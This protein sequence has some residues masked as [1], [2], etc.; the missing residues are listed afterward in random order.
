[1]AVSWWNSALDRESREFILTLMFGKG[2]SLSFALNEHMAKALLATL[3]GHF[4]AGALGA[5]PEIA[6]NILPWPEQPSERTFG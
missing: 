5:V 3:R 1:M 4:E 2:G 6:A